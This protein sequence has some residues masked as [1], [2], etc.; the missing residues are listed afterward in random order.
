MSLAAA[1]P[2]EGRLRSFGNVLMALMLR[3][4]R[5]RMLGSAWGFMLVVAWPLTHMTFVI[6]LIA[7]RNGHMPPY[8]DSM[9]VWVATGVIPFMCFSYTARYVT[10]AIVLNRPLLAFPIISV[11]QLLISRSIIE[12]LNSSMVIIIIC[13]I[14]YAIGEPLTPR[15]PAGAGFAMIAAFFLGLG[16]GMINALIAGMAPAW[17]TAFNLMIVVLWLSAGII[18]IPSTLPENVRTIMS[19]H[20]LIQITEWARSAYYDSYFSVVLDQN[21]LIVWCVAILFFALLVERSMRS[22]IVNR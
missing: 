19:Y 12:L 22:Y 13:L 1:S 2:A 16:F 9:A 3:D 4:V 15:Y 18:F 7:A 8:G 11:M 14:F 17:L 10:T 6:L 21:Y 20:P 5:T